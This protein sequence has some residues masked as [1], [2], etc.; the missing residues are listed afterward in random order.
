MTLQQLPK[1]QTRTP[2]ILWI[3]VP[4]T[5]LLLIFPVIG[6]ALGLSEIPHTG[7]GCD[8]YP[9]PVCGDQGTNLWLSVSGVITLLVLFLAATL[10][11]YFVHRKQSASFRYWPS[12]VAV[13]GVTLVLGG[14]LFLIFRLSTS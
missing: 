3:I 1:I 5:I 14:V 7:K 10:L 2:Q 13:F 6:V 8:A 11:T 12:I 9:G 4:L